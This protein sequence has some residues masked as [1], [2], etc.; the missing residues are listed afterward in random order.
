MRDFSV[1]NPLDMVSTLSPGTK[2]NVTCI[3]DQ[4]FIDKPQSY[5]A[6]NIT[7]WATYKLPLGIS[8]CQATK[9][10][11]KPVSDGTYI[12]TYRGSLNCKDLNNR[13]SG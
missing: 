8:A 12:W 9:F 3:L 4:L 1:M 6:L 5:G 11:G 7:L 10:S 2:T 13:D